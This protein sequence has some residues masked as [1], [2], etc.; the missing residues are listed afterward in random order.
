MDTTEKVTELNSEVSEKDKSLDEIYRKYAWDY[1]AL[2]AGQRIAGFQFFVTLSTAI[3]GGYILLLRNTGGQKWMAALGILLIF[4]SFVFAKLDA[5][6][7]RLVKNGEDALKHLDELQQLPD[8]DDLPHPLRMFS[9][10]DAVVAKLKPTY[11]FFGHFS[12]SRC[13]QYVFVAFGLLG[14]ISAVLSWCLFPISSG[15]PEIAI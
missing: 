4:I 8:V 3:V 13:F 15:L 14:L 6:A 5:R 11:P 12:Y 1:F 7:K 2:H 9:R 10:D